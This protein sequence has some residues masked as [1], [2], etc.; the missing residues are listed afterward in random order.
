MKHE[1]SCAVCKKPLREEQ[2]SSA[3]SEARDWAK[4]LVQR[5]S[6]GPGD[7]ENAMRRLEARYGIP[8]STFWGL[9]YRPPKDIYVGAYER[10]RDAYLVEHEKQQRLL[11]HET[12]ITK[13]KSGVS[14]AFARAGAAFGRAADAVD[15]A[16]D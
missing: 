1:R 11:R 5:E 16:E 10:L 8:F 14:T 9:R 15:G 12:E 7:I 3:V 6:R 4:W 13:A 2:M